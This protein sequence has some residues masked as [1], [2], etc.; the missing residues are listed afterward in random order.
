PR[1]DTPAE[2]MRDHVP[3]AVKAERMQRLQQVCKAAAKRYAA[4]FLGR[5]ERVL[6]ESRSK[7]SGLMT[8]TSDHYLQVEFAASPSLVGQL[9]PVRIT[10]IAPDGV[11]GELVATAR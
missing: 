9:A 1:P 6:V 11:L 4:R 3:D 7:L 2:Q 10:D 8:G 5:T